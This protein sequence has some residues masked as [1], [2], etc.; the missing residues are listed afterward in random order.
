MTSGRNAL[1]GIAALFKSDAKVGDRLPY[2]R[3]IDE[4]T[5]LLRDGSLMQSIQLDGFAFETA[6]T[7]EVNHRQVL[8]NAAFRAIG[9]SRF[10]VYHHIIRRRV[11]VGFESHFENPAAALIDARWQEPKF[12][13]W[14]AMALNAKNGMYINRRY[15][16]WM[17]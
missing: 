14:S 15:I 16:P 17:M 3:L 1:Y 6:D 2:D 12:N 7:D 8:R 5:I 4:R 9:N 13:P 10:V 11:R